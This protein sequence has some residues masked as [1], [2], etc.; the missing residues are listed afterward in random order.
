LS[1]YTTSYEYTG[2]QAMNIQDNRLWI[3]RTTGYEYTGQ[4]STCSKLHLHKVVNHN[5]YSP[6]AKGCLTNFLCKCLYRSSSG[7]TATAVSPT[8]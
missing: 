8:I 7:W 2:Q 5:R 6:S 3:Y 4:Q 1:Q